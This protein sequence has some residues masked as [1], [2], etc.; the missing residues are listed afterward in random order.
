M[1]IYCTNCAEPWDAGDPD[2]DRR[3]VLNGNCEYCHGDAS[4]ARQS[5][6]TDAM[7]MLGDLLGDDIDGMAAMM[8]DYEYM[9]MLD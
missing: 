3:E 6:R 5:L 2:I 4:K 8:D 1:D 9:G 7:S